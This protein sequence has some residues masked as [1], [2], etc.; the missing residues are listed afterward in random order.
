[1]TP[2][3]PTQSKTI[4]TDLVMAQH[5]NPAGTLFGGVL[6][7]W[8]DKAAL[9]TATNH[10]ERVAVTVSVDNIVFLEKAYVGDQV[11][12]IACVNYVGRS[13][14][15][16]GMKVTSRNPLRFQGE[17]HIMSAYFTF[18][19]IDENSKTTEVPRLLLETDEERRRYH[20][21]ELRVR[22]RARVRERL[23]RKFGAH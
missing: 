15:E 4:I 11:T 13:S 7:G 21:A 10:C 12:I 6:M 1:M 20:E 19:A 17:K 2:K 8:L 18:V 23:L 14:M 16:I 5:T 9:I 22:I 3:T